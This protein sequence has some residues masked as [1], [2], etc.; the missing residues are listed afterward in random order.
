MFEHV[1]DL[2]TF[3]I[4]ACLLFAHDCLMILFGICAR[5]AIVILF[6]VSARLAV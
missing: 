6:A 5:Y 1:C 3:A 2:C 4:A